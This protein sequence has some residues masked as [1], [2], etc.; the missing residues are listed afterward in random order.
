M[1]TVKK[2]A[3][4]V[5]F[6]VV[7]LVGAAAAF[8]GVVQVRGVP[9]YTPEPVEMHVEAT[10]A[11]LERGQKLVGLL[12]A[13]CH[14]DSTTGKLTGK[15][16]LDAPAAFG[17]IV[18]KNITQHPTKGIG[19]WT[20]GQLA[21][22]LRTGIAPDGHYAP[23]WMVKLP[24]M[25]DE[26]MASVI[27][28][29]RRSDDP[30]LAPADVDPPGR[31]EPSFVTKLLTN[32]VIK[33]LP[34][35]KTPISEPA[36]EDAVAWGRYLAITYD[37]YGC[38]SAD[39]AKLD[40]LVPE[41]SAGYFG[42][43]NVMNQAD[44]SPITTANLTPDEE[45]GI[46]RWSEAD[47]SRAVKRGFRPDGR[48]L[49]SPMMPKAELRDDEIHALYSYLKTV[50]KLRTNHDRRFAPAPPDAD[51]GKRLFVSYGCVSCHGE[52][53]VSVDGSADL[54]RAN[55]HF[56]TDAD[57]RAWIDEAPSKKPGT[58]MPGWKG[59]IAEGDY[60]PLMGHVRKLARA[61]REASN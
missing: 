34:Y 9:S 43:G 2:V 30:R 47:F 7:A 5:G 23:P 31:S 40:A 26:D 21:Y 16:M 22:F 24:L 27:A 12:C 61:P 1:K 38:H 18:S 50:P 53:G 39:F 49:R 57:L 32:T 20:D 13:E 25:S 41:R 33:P 28:F 15:R 11:R 6:A 35:P 51:P 52:R 4:G 10:P 17:P 8:A 42:G 19:S 55:E 58:R 36:K 37:C 60:E 59:V 54:R 45:T 3:K 46:G 56:T 29:V 44:G 48:A 14:A